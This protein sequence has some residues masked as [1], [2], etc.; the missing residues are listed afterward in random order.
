MKISKRPATT[1]LV[2]ITIVF[3]AEISHVLAQVCSQAFCSVAYLYAFA[4][5]KEKEKGTLT[6]GMLADI[7]V[8]SQDIFTIPTPSARNVISFNFNRATNF[9]III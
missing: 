5:F 2:I 4:E 1:S 9:K 3:I 6:K 7:A 8:L